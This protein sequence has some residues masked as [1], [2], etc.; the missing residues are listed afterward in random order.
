M[1]TSSDIEELLKVLYLQFE[2]DEL[3]QIWT[4]P[5]NLYNSFRP[6]LSGKSLV[7]TSSTLKQLSQGLSQWQRKQRI[8]REFLVFAV[9]YAVVFCVLFFF[10]LLLSVS[11]VV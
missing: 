10:L 3:N 9:V 7:E 6:P 8:S 5:H 1:E 2:R 4:F 11:Y